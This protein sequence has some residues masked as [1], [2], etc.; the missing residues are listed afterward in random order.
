MSFDIVW[1]ADDCQYKV[2]KV[3]DE[4]FAAALDMGDM[5]WL[6]SDKSTDLEKSIE[7]AKEAE[8]RR[9]QIN[10]SFDSE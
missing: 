2:I 1:E 4:V 7:D 6:V 5:G 8:F 10:I 9:K 3:S